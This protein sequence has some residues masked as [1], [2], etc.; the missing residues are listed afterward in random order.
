M[1][2]N[3]CV[4]RN[5]D[6]F[7]PWLANSAGQ[8]LSVLRFCLTT[9][10]LTPL[11]ITSITRSGTTATAT[12]LS[13]ANLANGLSV[14]ISGASDSLYNATGPLTIAS[15]TTFTYTMSGTPAASPAVGTLI[16]TPQPQSIT[17]ITRSGS[18]ATAVLAIG[19]PSMV[20]GDL[21]TFGG[22]GQAEYNVTAPITVV[23]STHVTFQVAG[24]PATPATGTLTH[25]KAGAGWTEPFSGTNKAVFLPGATNNSARFYLRVLDDG[26][27]ASAVQAMGRGYES[28]SDVDTGTNPFPTVAQATN[29]MY[30]RK[31][32]SSAVTWAYVAD[33][34][35]FTN[36]VD[37]NGGASVAFSN[38]HF[39][40]WFP[41]NKPADAFNCA[42]GGDASSNVNNSQAAFYACPLGGVS[43]STVFIARAVSQTGGAVIAGVQALVYNISNLVHGYTLGIG[44]VPY[45]SPA[46]GGLNVQPLF[47][48]ESG[49]D[50]GRLP[51]Y[52]HIHSA[53]SASL[54]DKFTGV[55]GLPGITLMYV[56]CK[57]TST[58]GC[59]LADITGP[60]A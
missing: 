43:P 36:W 24:S 26:S 45:P 58:T 17:G 47:I 13:T 31:G 46:H 11:P 59:Y 8:L 30:W 56:H 7:A 40:G 48:G 20:T 28:M 29:G 55:Q 37:S 2:N 52:A 21:H 60:W 32:V 51:L 35:F 25:Y 19:D 10:A 9:G 49:C 53:F 27:V 50:R 18:T 39:F 3:V 34:R 1:A 5:S 4:Y 16:M 6:L 15:S 54:G 22:A 23:D 57:N 44:S 42:I 12:V 33:D 41:S 38:N 14:A